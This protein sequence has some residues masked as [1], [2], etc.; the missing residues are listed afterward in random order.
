MQ[1]NEQVVE[2]EALM[3]NPADEVSQALKR[4]ILAEDRQRPNTYRAHAEASIDDD[5]GGRFAVRKPAT[6][7]GASPIQY[8]RLPQDAPANQAAM[9]GPEAP[10][11]YDINA[12]DCTGEVHERATQPASDGPVRRG[13][14]RI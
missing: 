1:G 6:V 10:L 5:R 12:M 11:G 14:R 7:I 8:P 2:V 4:K 13:W 9:V 3:N